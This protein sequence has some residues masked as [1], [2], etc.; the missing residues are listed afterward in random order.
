VDVAFTEAAVGAGI[1]TVLMLG[2]LALTGHREAAPRHSPLL[3]LLVVTVTGAVLIWGTTDMPP[4]ADPAAPIHAHVAP[5]YI[6]D[7]PR[8]VGVPNMV[9]SVL[10]SYRG[11]DTMGEVTVIFTAGVGVLALLGV[12]RRR[13]G[14][15]A[16][17]PGVTPRSPPESASRTDRERAEGRGPGTE[18]APDARRRAGSAP[19]GA[20]GGGRSAA[21]MRED[22]PR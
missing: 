5:R 22:Q 11:Y 4:F 10:A 16:S 1:S 8:E 13:G 21:P 2:T 9:T 20:A 7:S 17:P 19:T 18:E 15:R 3:P 12:R 6:Q 14:R